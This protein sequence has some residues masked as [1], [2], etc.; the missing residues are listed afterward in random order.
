LLLKEGSVVDATIIAAP[1][2]VKNK[3]QAP[4]V[5]HFDQ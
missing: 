3:K 5:R 2:S 4:G 1:P